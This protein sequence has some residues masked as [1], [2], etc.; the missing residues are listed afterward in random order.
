MY[1]YLNYIANDL[2]YNIL[3]LNFTTLIKVFKKI[4]QCKAIYS[5]H[6]VKAYLK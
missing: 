3:M 1:S 6:D 4:I 5:I 2:I